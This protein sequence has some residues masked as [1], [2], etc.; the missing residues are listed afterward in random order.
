MRP[1]V[2]V[3]GSANMDMVLSMPRMPQEGESIVSEHYAYIP[4]GKGANAAVSA[5]RVGADVIFCARIGNDENGERLL[6][7][8]R[9][10]GID[11]RYVKRDK[12]GSTGLA[13]VLLD[14]RTGKNRIVVYPSANLNLT[15]DDVETAFLSYPDAVFIQFETNANAIIAATEFAAQQK[16][17]VFIDA[18]PFRKD[19]AM[20]VYELLQ[21]VEI[22]SPNEVEM[23]QMTG[24]NPTNA[25]TCLQACIKL[26]SM[27]KAKNIVIKLSDRGCFLYDGKY[28]EM[29]T[30]N[31][32]KAVDTTAAGDAFTAALAVEYL[33]TKKLSHSCK[34][35][36]VAG[37]L[38]VT[39]FGAMSSLPTGN[40]IE[41]FIAARNLKI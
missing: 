36:N 6:D 17:P 27:I 20:P 11:V 34:Y 21:N 39:Q 12:T 28:H 33:K 37:A 2:L 31:N 9:G 24:I 3:V 26:N 32:V 1:R 25:E 10:E 38:A 16:I 35:A 15:V 29:I 14:E 7:A 5:A 30:A 19:F 22:L 4:G 13:V 8:Y 23:A 40:Q 18:G 41:T